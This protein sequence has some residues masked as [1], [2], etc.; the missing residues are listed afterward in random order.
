MVQVVQE[1]ILVGDGRQSTD[2]RFG[3]GIHV[4][5]NIGSTPAIIGI[6]HNF[7]VSRDEQTVE[8]EVCSKVVQL[9]ER[10]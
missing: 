5:R 7:P 3:G 6:Q 4:M 2:H 10:R 9:G 1:T 8:A